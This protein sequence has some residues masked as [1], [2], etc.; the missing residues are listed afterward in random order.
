MTKR[1]DAQFAEMIRFAI[2]MCADE[3]T[4]VN[5]Q[6]KESTPDHRTVTGELALAVRELIGQ[7]EQ[8]F[9]Q[10]VENLFPDHPDLARN[11][12]GGTS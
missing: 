5:R 6:R 9:G 10:V 7:H 3:I 11:R 12:Q 4:L 2:T 1:L 8:E